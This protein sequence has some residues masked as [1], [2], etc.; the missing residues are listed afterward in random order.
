MHVVKTDKHFIEDSKQIE[1][2]NDKTKTLKEVVPPNQ[3]LREH[4]ENASLG[5]PSLFLV[6]LAENWVENAT[7]KPLSPDWFNYLSNK[8]IFSAI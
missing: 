7:I 8:N 6:F 5:P 3:N 2:V 1:P 4:S